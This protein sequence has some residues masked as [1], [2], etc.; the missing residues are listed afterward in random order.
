MESIVGTHRSFY[1]LPGALLSQDRNPVGSDDAW[2]A[3]NEHTLSEYNYGT[4]HPL[5]LLSDLRDL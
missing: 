2:K 3:C 1:S 5:G 4:Y